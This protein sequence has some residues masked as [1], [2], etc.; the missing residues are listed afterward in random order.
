MD[1]GTSGAS[2]EDGQPYMTDGNLR[3]LRESDIRLIALDLDGTVLTDDKR[4]TPR[5]EAAIVSAARSG[6]LVVPDTGRPFAGIPKELAAIHDIRYYIT[7]NG[8]VTKDIYTGQVLRSACLDAETAVGIAEIPMKKNLVHDVFIDGVGYCEPSFHEK[9][10][11]FF[12]NTPLMPYV[13][14]SRRSTEDL[15]R[16]IRESRYGVENIWFIAADQAERDELDAYIRANF[17]VHTVL[18]AARDVEAGSPMAEKGL[19]LAAL[20]DELGIRKDQILAVGDNE[21]DIGLLNAAG[22]AV[23]MENG[24]D[25]AK[26]IA[27]IIA[28]PNSEDGAAAVIEEVLKN[29]M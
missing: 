19:A 13:L 6:I 3:R 12:R 16:L 1:V 8:A 2:G 9:L 20:A 24:T 21:N 7:S 27:D 17:P 5:M 26:R 28:P 18:T 29:R 14:Q 11:G 25:G 15:V 4:M 22:I 23:A 10:L